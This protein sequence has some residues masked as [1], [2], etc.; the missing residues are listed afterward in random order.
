MRTPM[1]AASA[2]QPSYFMACTS[3]PPNWSGTQ[4]T[5]RTART[6]GGSSAHQRQSPPSAATTLTSRISTS[7]IPRTGFRPS[8]RRRNASGTS[9]YSSTRGRRTASPR[10][11][12]RPTTAGTRPWRSTRPA[13]STAARGDPGDAPQRRRLNRQYRLDLRPRRRARLHR[14]HRQQGRRDRDDQGR[15]ARTR[16]APH[17][18]QC[19]LSGARQ[20]TD[21]RRGRRRLPSTSRRFAVAPNLKKSPRPSRFWPPTTPSTSPAPSSAVDG[22]YLA[23]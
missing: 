1:P 3:A 6:Y 4:Q 16:P 21:E 14:L 7:P 23:R 2:C 10:S 18:G 11:S 17:Q 22:G 12:T 20:D 13:S 9:T 19:D 15:H 5:E 8:A